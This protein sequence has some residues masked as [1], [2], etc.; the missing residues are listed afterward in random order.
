MSDSFVFAVN[1]VLNER[2]FSKYRVVGENG[3]QN[4]EQRIAAFQ[5][6]I[7]TAVETFNASVLLLQEFDAA[8]W[9]EMPAPVRTWNLVMHRD[10]TEPR[11]GPAI[12]VDPA[13]WGI[14]DHDDCA[15]SYDFQGNGWAAVVLLHHLSGR[16][17]CFT[18]VHAKWGSMVIERM[19]HA[20]CT[21]GGVASDVAHVIAGDFNKE[22]PAM[23]GCGVVPALPARIAT[24]YSNTTKTNAL[25]PYDHIF[26]RGVAARLDAVT[27]PTR[28]LSHGHGDK[29]L[30]S[31][32]CAQFHSDHAMIVCSAM[33]T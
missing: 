25:V 33:F 21:T 18:S 14:L 3:P 23:F 2:W 20:Y 6:E 30:G 19:L 31:L 27:A 28:L 5:R 8:L 4:T 32:D 22:E 17:V 9:A 11:P 24:H 13:V 1:N 26:V 15:S 12:V 7:A 10:E 16:H 29:L